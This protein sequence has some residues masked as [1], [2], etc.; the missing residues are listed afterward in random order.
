[1]LENIHVKLPLIDWIWRVRGS[2]RMDPPLTTDE[3]FAR[4]EPLFRADGTNHSIEGDTLTYDKV[5]PAAQDVMATFTKG[6]LR[7]A[8][9][10]GVQKLVFS[11]SSPALLCCFLAPFLFLTFAQV[12]VYLNA[13]ETPAAEAAGAGEEEEEEEEDKEVPQ[14]HPIDV[15]LGAPAPE[16][17]NAE[18]AEGRGEEEEE[19]EGKHS[20]TPA[21][22]LAGLFAALFLVGRMLEPWL[23][24]RMFRKALA[25]PPAT[26]EPVADGEMEAQRPG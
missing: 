11:L 23:I 14:L 12:T 13:L 25:N 18:D 19:E 24:K 20:P 17:P 16:D 6:T 26:T 7:I 9:E 8:Y 3:T 15:F 1:M 22:V 10:N 21:Y 4:I 2:V 5:N